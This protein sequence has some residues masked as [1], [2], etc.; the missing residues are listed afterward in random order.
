MRAMKQDLAFTSH[1]PGR[2]LIALPVSRAVAVIAGA[3]QQA[4]MPRPAVGSLTHSD[5][6]DMDFLRRLREAGL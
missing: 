5:R 4:A 2:A 3:R 6:S 1:A